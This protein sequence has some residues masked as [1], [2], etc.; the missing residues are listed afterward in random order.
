MGSAVKVTSRGATPEVGFAEMESVRGS[1]GDT[2]MVRW[3]SEA[4]VEAE[5][6]T[7]RVTP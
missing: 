5:S 3:L 1:G 4:L 6:V 2:S 7:V